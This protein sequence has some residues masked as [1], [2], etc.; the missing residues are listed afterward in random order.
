M[1]CIWMPMKP[2]I[3]LTNWRESMRK[4]KKFAKGLNKSRP[5]R[6][7]SKWWRNIKSV[8]NWISS[9]TSVNSTQRKP[10]KLA[11]LILTRRKSPC[12]NL[13]MTKR[14]SF[15][16]MTIWILSDTTKELL[17][18]LWK[19]L[20]NWSTVKSKLLSRE[21][22]EVSSLLWTTSNWTRPAQLWTVGGPSP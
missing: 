20:R 1:L 15:T 7:M 16:R 9:K 14:R 17:V 11:S 19:F 21:W 5:G 22:R 4:K 6:T 18:I 8:S 2:S 10:L 13:R 12:I 3:G